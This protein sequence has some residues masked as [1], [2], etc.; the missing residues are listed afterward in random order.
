MPRRRMTLRRIDPWSMLK[1][2]FVLNLCFLAIALL[3]A[4]IVWWVVNRLGLIE[5]A[6][7]LATEVGFEQ[8]G[9]NGGNLFRLLLL[10]GILGVVVQTALFVF[11]AF[12]HNLI[13]DLVGGIAVTLNEEGGS[14]ATT[15]AASTG[16]HTT[17]TGR[18][19]ERPRRSESAVTERR[20]AAAD[21]TAA[22][23][24]N[25]PLPA[26]TD[27]T[28]GSDDR[29]TPTGAPPRSG[30]DRSDDDVSWPWE[31]H[32]SA[33]TDGGTERRTDERIFGGDQ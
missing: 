18:S 32:R 26:G 33:T 31:R 5:Q 20:S 7:D 25:A 3:G 28:R 4:A 1:F 6:C 23:S 15:R 27:R 10:L 11:G 19:T 29:Q 22:T 17:T 14:I 12:L 21:D 24:S 2:G 8:C 9:V 30:E 16:A 13:A